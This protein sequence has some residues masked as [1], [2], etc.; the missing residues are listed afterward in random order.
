M[1]ELLLQPI[2]DVVTWVQL[3][4]PLPLDTSAVFW[5]YGHAWFQRLK[6]RALYEDRLD[7]LERELANPPSSAYDPVFARLALQLA[8]RELLTRLKAQLASPSQQSPGRYLVNHLAVALETSEAMEIHQVVRDLRDSRLIQDLERVMLGNGRDTAVS[9]RD[10]NS[11]LLGPWLDLV[12]AI[13]GAVYY[14]R[15]AVVGAG[16]GCVQRDLS[17]NALPILQELNRLRRQP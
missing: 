16:L 13:A 7:A 14:E 1:E 9:A 11:R 2:Q 15:W 6:P 12:D 5:F 8:C 17:W 3:N 4:H 10:A